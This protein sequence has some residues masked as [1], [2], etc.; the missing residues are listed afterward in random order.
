MAH[1][2]CYNYPIQRVRY[3]W[4]PSSDG[5][6]PPES[7]RGGF[8]ASHEPIYVARGCVENVWCAGKI[9]QSEGAA[10]FPLNGGEYRLQDYEVLCFRS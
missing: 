8:A 2:Y 7:I 9:L 5:N 6:V 1:I 4:L 3:K 10:Q